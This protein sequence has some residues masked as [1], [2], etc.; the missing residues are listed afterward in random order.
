VKA[1][2]SYMVEYDLDEIVG[3]MLDADY[4]FPISHAA[5]GGFIQDQFI[6]S[7]DSCRLN[8]H[9]PMDTSRTNRV[10]IHLGNSLVF[11][12]TQTGFDSRSKDV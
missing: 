11:A 1:Y 9:S 6:L 5:I 3:E 8:A 10:E 12:K 7:D 4:D 2:A